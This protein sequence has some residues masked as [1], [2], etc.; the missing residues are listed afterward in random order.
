MSPYLCVFDMRSQIVFEDPLMRQRPAHHQFE[1]NL[2]PF[3]AMYFEFYS[4]RLAAARVFSRETLKCLLSILR[5][6][7]VSFLQ[8]GDA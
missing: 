2:V 3:E 7:S 1:A 8:P 6:R 4:V 5:C